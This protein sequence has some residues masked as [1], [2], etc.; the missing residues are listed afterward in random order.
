MAVVLDPF[1][2]FLILD[3]VEEHTITDL[4]L[5]IPDN[6]GRDKP[7]VGTV[8]SCGPDVTFCKPGDMVVFSPFTGER[9]GLQVTALQHKEYHV[10]R[11]DALI[12]L[13]H[14]YPDAPPQAA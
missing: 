9:L 5:Y 10:V 13:Y 2:D 1:S 7:R 8:I 4:G 6:A 12:A 3:P 11:E 14:E